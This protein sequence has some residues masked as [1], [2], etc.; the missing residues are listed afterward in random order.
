MSAKIEAVIRTKALEA[1]LKISSI[2]STPTQVLSYAQEF[3][4][5]LR[6]GSMPKPVPARPEPTRPTGARAA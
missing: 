3:E 5:Y 4:K 6:E 2:G 1:A